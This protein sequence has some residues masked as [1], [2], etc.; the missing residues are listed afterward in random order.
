MRKII[1]GGLAGGLTLYV[2]SFI[3]HLPPIG[4]A[5]ERKLPPQVLA[6]MQPG[7]HERAVYI[8]PTA[9]VAYNPH[10]A[11]IASFFI[12]ELIAAFASAFLGAVIAAS[13][14]GSY[15]RRVLVLAAI[16]LVGT[17]DIEAGYWNWYG[18]PLSYLG[19]QPVDHAGGWLVTGM[20]LARATPRERASMQRNVRASPQPPTGLESS[21]ACRGT[22]RNV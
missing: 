15:W 13:L 7:L 12:I 5:G 1:I 14:A 3:A 22:K 19:A 20:V 6:A 18:Y 16:G 2:W 4:T 10:P 17:I 9:V 21:S 8:A 11:P